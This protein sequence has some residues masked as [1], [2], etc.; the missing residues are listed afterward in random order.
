MAASRE[1][2]Y[3]KA[4]PNGGA[5]FRNVFKSGRLLLSIPAQTL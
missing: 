2:E 4:T 3:R 5:T 1:N